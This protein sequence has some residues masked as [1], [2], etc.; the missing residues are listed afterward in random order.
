[1]SSLHNE[2]NKEK[3]RR[4]YIYVGFDWT[5]HDYKV[6]SICEIEGFL[7]TYKNTDI[8]DNIGGIDN[9]QITLSNEQNYVLDICKSQLEEI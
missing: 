3:L 1:M 7:K 2:T 6:R 4:R 9:N 8:T 5:K